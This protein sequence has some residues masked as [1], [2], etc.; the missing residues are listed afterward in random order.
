MDQALVAEVVPAGDNEHGGNPESLRRAH[1]ISLERPEPD[2][3][4]REDDVGIVRLDQRLQTP[5]K[6][7]RDLD[8]V[9]GC[10]QDAAERREPRQRANNRRRPL[11][12]AST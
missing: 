3:R 5:G 12:C 9:E 10:L 11:A 6:G 1:V 2:Q 4:R 7:Q 8:A